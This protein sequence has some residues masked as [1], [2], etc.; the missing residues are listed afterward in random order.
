LGR[1]HAP[2]VLAL[3]FGVTRS[4]ALLCFVGPGI[5]YFPHI[6]PP[7]ITIWQAAAPTSS[8]GFLLTEAVVM[9]PI[10]LIPIILT[11]MAYSYWTLAGKVEPSARYH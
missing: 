6:V 1:A 7:S 3:N 8:Q 10:I 11:Y 2:E 9:I 4:V 5:S